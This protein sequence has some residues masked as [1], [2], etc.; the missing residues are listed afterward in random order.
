MTLNCQ[1]V[2][3]HWG[4]AAGFLR[5]A[6]LA[7]AVWTRTAMT[8]TVVQIEDDNAQVL[9]GSMQDVNL[10]RSSAAGPVLQTTNSFCVGPCA[11]TTSALANGGSLQVA[12]PAIFNGGVG[13]STVV[14]N[15]VDVA[16]Q[17][18][19]LSAL[20]ATLQTQVATL[21]GQI[22]PVGS[23]APFAGGSLP[24]GWLLANGASVAVSAYSALFGVLGYS[25]GGSGANF[26]L[27]DM[28]GRFPLGAGQGSGLTNRV[29]ATTTGSET[30]ATAV[31]VSQQPAFTVPAHH[32]GISMNTGNDGPHSHK[33]STYS[34]PG[35]Q[36]GGTGA[37]AF[38]SLTT[39]TTD[40]DTTIGGTHS[41][42]I[43]G[44]VG[45]SSGSNGDA[46]FAATRSTNVALSN[47]AISVVP[48]ALAVSYI[49]KF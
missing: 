49:I 25:Y 14:V 48:P 36:E 42:T 23:L 31:T 1:P 6:V 24:S 32:H 28:R 11:N 44:T 7:I 34:T 10:F 38:I 43:S 29:L 26:A 19:S 12:G 30:T 13:A 3:R 33:V 27:P 39:G 41:H 4:V 35:V 20:I 5:F 40:F 8:S 18:Q 45:D 15:G 37:T 16:Q 9:L 21:Q 2:V 22:V 47:P 17:L 46:S